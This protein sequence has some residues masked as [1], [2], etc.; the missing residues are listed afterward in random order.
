MSAQY[1]DLTGRVVVV[2][3]GTALAVPADCT[4]EAALAAAAASSWITGQT[5]DVSG[6]RVMM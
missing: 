1:L 3:G 5:I 6:G 2:T 4:D